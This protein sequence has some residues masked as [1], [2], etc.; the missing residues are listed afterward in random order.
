M[1]G[2]LFGDLAGSAYEFRNTHDYHFRMI[3]RYSAPTDDSY[4]TLAAAKALMETYG[5]SDEV[6][7]KKL[8]EQMQMMGRKYPHAGYGGMFAKW[9]KSE[10][11][12]PYG[13][14][15]NGSAMR[16]SPAGW[17]YTTMDETMHAA[18]LTAEVTHNHS[19]GIKGAKA[20]AAC[21]YLARMKAEKKDILNYVSNVFGYNM[22]F[23][24]DSIRKNYAFD[25]TCPGSVPQAI[26]AFYEGKDYEDVIRLAVSLGG[27]SDTIACMAGGIAEAYYGMPEAFRK[28]E[29]EHLDQDC[30]NIVHDFRSFYH[31]HSGRPADDLKHLFTLAGPDAVVNENLEDILL[32]T[33]EDITNRKLHWALLDQIVYDARIHIPVI[34]DKG[35]PQKRNAAPS[36]T[37]APDGSTAMAVFTSSSVLLTSSISHDDIITWHLDSMM[38]FVLEDK[39]VSGLWINGEEGLFLD[40][41][42]I[43]EILLEA[44]KERDRMMKPDE[45]VTYHAIQPHPSLVENIRKY[46]EESALPV[47][48]VSYRE[49]DDGSILLHLNCQEDKAEEA[50]ELLRIALHACYGPYLHFHITTGNDSV[51]GKA[52]LIYQRKQVPD[53]V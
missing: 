31:A 14:F 49:G 20:I 44:E 51:P 9:L 46:I 18:V 5:E 15:G 40:K 19:E 37:T 52:V 45:S 26:R 2:A 23:T 38:N 10:N 53:A 3:T 22:N 1:L 17:L 33:K 24:L 11:P 42:G 48:D 43:R 28:M 36:I 6:I 39:Q 35:W 16:V 25:E 7:R 41:S 32:Y 50:G 47:S 13:S 34:T 8:V 30:R 27:D 29:L 12:H 21:I 4:M